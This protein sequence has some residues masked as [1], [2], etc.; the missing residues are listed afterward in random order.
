MGVVHPPSM[1][2]RCIVS[3]LTLKDLFTILSPSVVR[4]A[5]TWYTTPD[6]PAVKFILVVLPLTLVA[7]PPIAVDVASVGDPSA[8]LVI[9]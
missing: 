3:T 1:Y 9:A 6:V 7:D 8:S 2:Y 4:V 5:V